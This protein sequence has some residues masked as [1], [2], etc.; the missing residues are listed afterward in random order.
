MSNKNNVIN[1]YELPAVQKY[2]VKYHNPTFDKTNQPLKH[3]MR[4]IV[5][6]ATGSG[7]SNIL[8]NIMRSMNGTFENILIFTQDKD[9]TLYKYLEQEFPDIRIYEGISTVKNFN[10]NSIPDEQTLIIFDDMCVE[11]F[12]DQK[13]ICEL[14]IRG[15]KMAQGAGISLVYLTQSYF[16]VPP[17]IRKQ[18]NYL[19]LRKI[20]GTRD[21]NAILR[22]CSIDSENKTK[23]FKMY[24]FCCD[25]DDI[26]AFLFIDL[27]APEKER[28]RYQ[29]DD[30][31][32]IDDFDDYD[33]F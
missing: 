17:I 12:K 31:L 9:E 32:N 23:L 25:P 30:V 14:F 24:E 13:D 28:F 11:S 20:N 27:G 4:T 1:F 15:R 29:F 6:G 7:K 19:I 22:E 16:Q 10:F 26:K 33:N 3:P 5:C 2:A 21:L 8:L 18:M